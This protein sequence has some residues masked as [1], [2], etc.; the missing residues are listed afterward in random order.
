MS[1][2]L[3]TGAAG[4]LGTKVTSYLSNR[5]KIYATDIQTKPLKVIEK[6]NNNIIIYQLDISK[7]K[8]VKD[9]FLKL[10]RNKIFINNVISLAAIDSKP[11]SNGN[12]NKYINDKKFWQKE[13]DVSINGNLNLFKYF[14][15]EMVKKKNGKFLIL[16]SDLSVIA[17]NQN[18]YKKAFGKFIKPP[19]YPIIKHA[20]YG[21]IKYYA[22]LYAKYNVNVNMISPGPIYNNHP[23]KFESE[24]KKIIPAG[25]MA[26]RENILPSIDFLLDKNNSFINGQNILIDGGRTII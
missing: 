19:S 22:S 2:I 13:I 18:I 15:E 23:K 16:G 20:L 24:L 1:N 9:Y 12:K 25:K 5:N 21:M 14:G 4:F 17:P 6:K 3:I 11:V 26:N 8:N 7:E 10:K